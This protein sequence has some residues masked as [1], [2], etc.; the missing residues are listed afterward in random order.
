MPQ[1]H[2]RRLRVA[3]RYPE[4]RQHVPVLKALGVD[5]MS[6]DEEDFT[7]PGFRLFRVLRQ[8]WRATEVTT[9]LRVL[10]AVHHRWRS[11]TGQGP[12]RGAP[13]HFRFLSDVDSDPCRPIPGLPRNAYNASWLTNETTAMVR[14]DLNV[15][16]TV[17]DFSHSH[18][19]EV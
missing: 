3:L 2:Q 15:Q 4:T 14:E 11:P 1:A 12:Q 7:N 18:E 9:M 16:D 5:G 8:R 19:V 13:P 6:S 17:Y 10:D